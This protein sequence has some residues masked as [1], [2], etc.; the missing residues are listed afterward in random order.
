MSA[1]P[2]NRRS[3]KP[4]A[5]KLPP[6]RV[7]QKVASCHIMVTW[8]PTGEQLSLPELARRFDLRPS[9]LRDR[10]NRAGRPEVVGEAL[11]RPKVERNQDQVTVDYP[12]HGRIGFAEIRAIHAGLGRSGAYFFARWRAAGCPSVVDAE[13]FTCNG[14]HGQNQW[15]DEEEAAA[16]EERQADAAW[17]ALLC[18]STV[19]LVLHSSDGRVR[20]ANCRVPS[21]PIRC[22]NF[23]RTAAM[24]SSGKAKNRSR[25]SV[26]QSDRAGLSSAKAFVT[27]VR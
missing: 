14:H 12:P 5:R 10:W 11:V 23:V 4:P 18:P 22:A 9:L 19:N 13:L 8:Q 25:C 3:P 17:A 7:L 21:L 6:A 1:Q 20:S 16:E 24:S 27:S 15:T 2:A 26:D